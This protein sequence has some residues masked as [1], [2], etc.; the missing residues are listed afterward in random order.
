MADKR[1]MQ[2]S[3]RQLQRVKTWQLVV[4]FILMSFVS[5]TF[6]RLNNIGMVERRSAVMSADNEGYDKT[7]QDRLYDLQ[8]YVSAH[9][10]TDLGK[11]IF[12]EKTYNRDYSKLLTEAS[13]YN[14]PNGNIYK[15]VQEVC[16]P[17]FSRWSLAYVQCTANEL[18]KYPAGENLASSVSL[19]TDLYIHNFVSPFWSPDFAGWSVLISVVIL[20]MIIIRLL[21]VIVLKLLI[22]RRYKSI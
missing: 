21:G 16:M 15:K 8:N 3:M 4:L 1:K 12:L 18:S 14:N 10:N 7:T 20:I 11:G 13:N 17:Q 9:M 5:A 2:H 22:R 6:L 19:S